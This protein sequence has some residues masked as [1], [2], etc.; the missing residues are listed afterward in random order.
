MVC[1]FG[2][3]HSFAQAAGRIEEHYGLCLGESMVRAITLRHAER[4]QR[5]WAQQPCAQSSG[6]A[7]QSIIAEMDGSMVP[8]VRTAHAQSVADARKTRRTE[9]KEIRLCAAQVKG[10]V[11]AIYSTS[12]DQGVLHAGLEWRKIVD[13]AGA[14]EET[15]IHGVGDGAPWI[16]AEFDRQF[17]TAGHYLIDF[18]HVSEYL[19][20][21]AAL[22][23]PQSPDLWRHNQQ[24][25]LKAGQIDQVLSNL[26]A[27][28]QDSEAVRKA[29]TYL[30]ERNEH[31]DYS[32]A[33]AKEL[34]IG[35]GLIE[36]GHRHV[37]QKRLKLPGAWWKIESARAMA[38]LRIIK[39]NSLWKHFWAA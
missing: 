19:A 9:W 38:T 29:A 35:S 34:P 15:S 10:E 18:Y 28:P 33:I 2:S 21:A 6:P 25:L 3:E 30:Q 26:H 22:A 13:M 16:A 4:A 7:P 5:F 11:S 36:S 8:I 12:L 1:D 17:G 20:Q 39:A 23:S 37:L 27:L 24:E 31:L 14:N 32:G